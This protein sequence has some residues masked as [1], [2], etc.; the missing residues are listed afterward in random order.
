MGGRRPYRLATDAGGTVIRGSAFRSGLGTR[1]IKSLR[2]YQ[3]AV[4][5]AGTL[6]AEGGG[7]GHGV[8]LCQW[9]ARGY[10]QR[11]ASSAE[12]VAFYFPGTVIGNA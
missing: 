7:L 10:A 12:I 3:L 2:I 4:T 5:G 11:G 9:G 6:H 1:V 8:G